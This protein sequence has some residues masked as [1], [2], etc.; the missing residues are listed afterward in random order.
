MGGKGKNHGRQV[1]RAKARKAGG[2]STE[3]E[4][5]LAALELTQAARDSFIQGGAVSAEHEY[6]RS[7]NVVS[8]GA[9]VEL[10]E[11]CRWE[12]TAEKLGAADSDSYHIDKCVICNRDI[13][14]G[15]FAL[16]HQLFKAAGSEDE[17]VTNVR[18][19][20][21]MWCFDCS[22]K[23]ARKHKQSRANNLPMM[24]LKA[25][26]DETKSDMHS[27]DG[28]GAGVGAAGGSSAVAA[29]GEGGG[30]T[31]DED[32]RTAVRVVQ[33]YNPAFGAKRVAQELRQRLQLTVSDKRAKKFM[34]PVY[35]HGAICTV[36]EVFPRSPASTAGLAEDDVIVQLGTLDGGRDRV[37]GG[38]AFVGIVES[39]VPLIVEG[40]TIEAIVLRST[41]DG[42]LLIELTPQ[43]W[44]G[45]GLL[46]CRL[47]PHQTH[48][49]K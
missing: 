1:N 5:E 38:A 13:T 2:K 4:K 7:S 33:M 46:G 37:E 43:Q 29:V 20:P 36:G 31:G 18:T 17:T 44:E 42:P 25:K 19:L 6:L 35:Q 47:L 40:K 15:D 39:V 21:R 14:K 30:I 11:A 9:R 16:E 41:A 12:L 28:G 26:W 45:G 48:L 8:S 22:I 27:G 23:N 32:V 3:L 34:F 24:T 49:E 10:T